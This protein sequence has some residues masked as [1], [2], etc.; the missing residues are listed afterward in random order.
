[1]GA[2]MS[3]RPQQHFHRTCLQS[4]HFYSL[5]R[6]RKRARALLT[7]TSTGHNTYFSKIHYKSHLLNIGKQYELHNKSPIFCY[8]ELVNSRMEL[9]GSSHSDLRLLAVRSDELTDQIVLTDPNRHLVP[10][11]PFLP[12]KKTF[13]SSFRPIF[14]LGLLLPKFS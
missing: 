5:E 3:G 6:K 2:T 13:L 8:L 7:N 11:R 12:V 9:L 1:M 4:K 10:E 14:V